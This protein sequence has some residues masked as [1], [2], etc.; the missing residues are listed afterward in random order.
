MLAMGVLSSPSLGLCSRCRPP[1]FRLSR[2]LH[3]YDDANSGPSVPRSTLLGS[4][5]VPGGRA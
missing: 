2:L 5:A 4:R 1:L 3:S